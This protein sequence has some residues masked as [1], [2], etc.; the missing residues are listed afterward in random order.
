MF[1]SQVSTKTLHVAQTVYDGGSHLRIEHQVAGLVTEGNNSSLQSVNLT[2]A[3][4][5][6]NRLKVQ[7][8]IQTAVIDISIVHVLV[9][10]VDD[11][12]LGRWQQSA[13]TACRRRYHNAV[14]SHF[15]T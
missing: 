8:G 2:F 9:V 6:L 4:H 14:R 15:V 13:S 10:V 12:Q 7:T 11:V 5:L 3:S 1:Q